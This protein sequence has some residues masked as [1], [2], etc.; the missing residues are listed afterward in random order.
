[1]KRILGV[2]LGAICIFCFAFTAFAGGCETYNGNNIN[3]QNYSV[4]AS[5]VKSNL[6]ICDDGSLM[7]VQ[8]LVNENK[9]LVQY[10]DSSFNFKSQKLIDTDYSVYGGF[11]AV[12]DTYFLLTGQNNP[13]QLSSVVCF[14]ITKYDKNWNRIASAELKDC[15]TTIP[16]DAGSARFC[17]SGSN[18]T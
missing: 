7:R 18:P 8:Y 6:H 4:W 14:A 11:Y 17:H 12:G 5:T 3:A 16:F 15:N 2:I 1:M 10:Y 13:S 9:V